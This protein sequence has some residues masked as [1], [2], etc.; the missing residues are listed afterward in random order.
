M[1][2]LL[3]LLPL[4]I[5]IFA[6]GNIADE[7]DVDQKLELSSKA[8]NMFWKWNYYNNLNGW[9]WSD[10]KW[11]WFGN[12]WGGA[13]CKAIEIYDMSEPTKWEIL[14]YHEGHAFDPDEANP[15]DLTIDLWIK[16]KILPYD[17]T[18]SSQPLFIE[19]DWEASPA[20]PRRFYQLSNEAIK[21]KA[22]YLGRGWYRIS[23]PYYA[24]WIGNTGKTQLYI[25]LI[26]DQDPGT[27]VIDNFGLK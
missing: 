18:T 11:T 26:W 4:I 9:Q 16:N 10:V 6:C 7:T 8:N 25:S 15:S 5:F 17:P 1:K 23:I 14:L 21:E 19:M 12:T 27:V 24:Q 13:K 3:I 2:K 20:G 22:K